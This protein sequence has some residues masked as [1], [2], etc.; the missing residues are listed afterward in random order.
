MSSQYPTRFSP[1]QAPPYQDA[2]AA[3]GLGGSRW[4]FV[5]AFS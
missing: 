4:F 1:M 5:S 2:D 3:Q